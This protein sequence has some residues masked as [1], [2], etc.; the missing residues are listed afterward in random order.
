M[1]RKLRLAIL[2][3]MLSAGSAGLVCAADTVTSGFYGGISH[4]E[5]GAEQGIKIGDAGNIGRFESS[6]GDA[7]APQALVFGGYRWRNDL[8]LEAVLG[9]VNS[10]RLQGRGGVGL[11]LPPG[12]DE[13]GRAW[14]LD[15]YGRWGFWRGFS[16]YGRLGYSQVDA[17][18]PSFSTSVAAVPVDRRPRDGL[19]YGVGLRYDIN[20]S[21]GLK[22]EYAR[23]ATHPDTPSLA[24]PD[25]DQVQ[26]GLQF[27]F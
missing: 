23:I 25:G 24:L 9:S 4:R 22:L 21:L 10:Y 8:A 6:L 5:N 17:M 3:A 19:S 20:R 27:R 18:P 16:L 2:I 12:S 7:T 11:L 15:V 1:N 13:A 26:F 14:N